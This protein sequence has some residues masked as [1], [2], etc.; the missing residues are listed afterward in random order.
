VALEPARPRT[1]QHGLFM[2]LSPEPEKLELTMARIRRLVGADKAGTPEILDTHRPDSYRIVGLANGPASI[3]ANSYQMPAHMA[4]RRFR[5]PQFAQV[6][7]EGGHPVYISCM[8]E[9]RMR[10]GA[11]LAYAGPWRT[12]GEWW[13]PEPWARDE[14]DVELQHGGVFRIHREL[15]TGRWFFDGRYD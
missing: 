9:E 14:W 10:G 3:T 1:E 11:V 12:A 8:A 13:K 7:L 4:L 6:R 2:P 15:S 5:P